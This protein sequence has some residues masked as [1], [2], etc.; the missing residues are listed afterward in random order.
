MN[1]TVSRPHARL[2]DNETLSARLTDKPCKI[3]SYTFEWRR[4]DQPGPHWVV[5]KTVNTTSTRASYSFK[6]KIAGPMNV[7]V[8]VTLVL[9]TH[10]GCIGNFIGI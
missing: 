10:A 9:S 6:P 7:R 1:L 2:L 3:R 5:L 4:A 8:R